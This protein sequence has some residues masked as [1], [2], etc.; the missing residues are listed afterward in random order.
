MNTFYK[1]INSSPNYQKSGYF[2][3]NIYIDIE[4]KVISDTIFVTYRDEVN[5]SY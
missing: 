5:Y 3:K 4:K 2:L 1:S